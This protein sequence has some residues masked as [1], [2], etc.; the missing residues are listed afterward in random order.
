VDPLERFAALVAP[1]Q[2][3]VPLDEAWALVGAHA[4]PGVAPEQVLAGF[5]ELAERCAGPTL[6][7]LLRL[8]F[9][10]EGF[11]GNTGAYYDADNSYASTVL[12]RRT[13][14]PISLAVLTMEV[15]RRVGVPLAGV[16][17]PGH[18]LLRDRV[19]PSVFVDPFARGRLLDV[20]GCEAIFRSVHGADARLDARALE[21]V[22]PRRILVRM[23]TNLRA[24]YAQQ[25]DAAALAWVL[26][27]LLAVPI[28]PRAERTALAAALGST[29]RFDQAADE[30]DLLAD[31]LGGSQA[32]D[33]RNAAVRLRARLN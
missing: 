23:L 28:V 9:A 6:D 30:L 11:V 3:V 32:D 16:S 5:D 26:R 22:D 24:I 18:F 8:L 27:L 15:G 19:D 33:H 29:G 7:H 10:D 14:I 21:P 4:H 17:M 1:E 12:A 2:D 31:E 25:D 13:G 20:A